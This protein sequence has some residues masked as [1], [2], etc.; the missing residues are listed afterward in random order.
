MQ[1]PWKGGVTRTLAGL[2]GDD[3]SMT[4]K[5]LSLLLP[6]TTTFVTAIPSPGAVRRRTT[7][8]GDA[9]GL[10]RAGPICT[11]PAERTHPGPFGRKQLC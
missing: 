10:I 6:A 1:P 4:A 5:L 7:S 11:Q 3:T 8:E 2:A 9:A